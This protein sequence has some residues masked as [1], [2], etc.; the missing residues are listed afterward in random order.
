MF[1]KTLLAAA[2][3][4]LAQPAEALTADE[5]FAA[6]KQLPW[7][8][9]GTYTLPM[10][11]SKLALPQGD[12]AVFGADAQRANRAL[13]NPAERPGMEGVLRGPVP[14]REEDGDVVELEPVVRVDHVQEERPRPARE[15]VDRLAF[16]DGE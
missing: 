13:G 14:A 6:L 11:G 1:R 9:T 3:L 8:G 7:V 16:H 5:Q 10:S 12:V 15:H 2:V 4:P